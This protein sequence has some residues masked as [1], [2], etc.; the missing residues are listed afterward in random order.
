LCACST[1]SRAGPK[2]S[3]PA[4]GKDIL[5]ATSTWISRFLSPSRSRSPR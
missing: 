2:S 1:R 4:S 5:P 3:T